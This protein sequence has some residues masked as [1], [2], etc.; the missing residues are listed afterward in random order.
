MDR[1]AAA[2]VL[3]FAHFSGDGPYNGEPLGQAF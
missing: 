3:S 2:L 1:R